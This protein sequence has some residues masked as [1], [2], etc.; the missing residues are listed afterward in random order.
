[1]VD[2]LG[3]LSFVYKS[4]G[5]LWKWVCLMNCEETVHQS[6]NLRKLAMRL[7]SVWLSF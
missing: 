2:L 4:S 6:I 5:D 7:Y 3:Q 1:M